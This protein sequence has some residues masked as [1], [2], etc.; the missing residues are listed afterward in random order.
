MVAFLW[1]VA[2]LAL[3]SPP[4]VEPWPESDRVTG[5]PGQPPVEFRHYAGYV[6]VG[7]GEEKALFYWFFEAPGRAEKKKPLVLW[8]NGGQ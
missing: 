1:V 8:L 2:F 6:M 7:R 3:A 5:L 4:G